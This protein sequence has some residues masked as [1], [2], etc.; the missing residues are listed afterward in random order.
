MEE[1]PRMLRMPEIPEKVRA[2]FY[3]VT[4]AG[5]L[6]AAALGHVEPDNVAAWS[7]LAAA[8]LATANTSTKP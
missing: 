7:G 2:Y 1:S 4:V 8:V 6:V 3:R 5:L